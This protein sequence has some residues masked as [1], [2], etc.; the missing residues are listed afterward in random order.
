MPIE[1]VKTLER[2]AST[3]KS[4]IDALEKEYLAGL[5]HKPQIEGATAPGANSE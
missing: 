3:R 1:Q 5:L 4:R 2:Q